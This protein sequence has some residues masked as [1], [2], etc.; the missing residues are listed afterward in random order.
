MIVLD[1]NVISEL[2]RGPAAG[3][4]VRSWVRALRET[5]AT[6]VINRAEILSGIAVLPDGKRKEALREVAED[7]FQML[8]VC[9]PLT[10]E[11]ASV[12]ATIVAGRRDKGRPIAAMDALVAAIAKQSGAALATRD[13]RD[14]E[15]L[16]LDLIDPWR[17]G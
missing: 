8:G 2:M 4:A 16:G 15:G 9:L 6:T 7:A 12:Y 17:G 11:C 10:P 1:T 13:V 14:F 5:P 3:P